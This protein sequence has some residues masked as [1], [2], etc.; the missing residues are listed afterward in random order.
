MAVHDRR[1]TPKPPAR[2]AAARRG[3]QAVA[4]A[5]W[6][7]FGEQSGI[8]EGVFDQAKHPRDGVPPNP[9]W[10][11][12]TG[13]GGGGTGSFLDKVIQRNKAVADLTGGASPGMR[14]SDELAADLQ[15]AGRVAGA[16]AAGLRTGGKSVINGTATA[17]KNVVTLGLDN[18]QLELIGVTKQDRD[19]GYNEAV[20]IATASGEVLIAVGTGGITAALSNGGKIAR[21]V[22]RGLV[23]LDA[24]GN[25]VGV[26]R[27][28]YDAKTNG[29]NLSNGT[30]IAAG[31]LGF[32]YNIGVARGLKTPSLL[33]KGFDPVNGFATFEDF[34]DAFGAAGPG[35]AW[36][37]IVEQTINSGKFAAELLHNPANLLKLPHGKGTIHAKI[38]GYY[39]SRRDFTGGLKV[40]EWLSKKSFKEQF[41]F[42]IQK[43]KE[44]GGTQYLPP[45][46]R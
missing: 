25:I 20:A 44:F 24:A 45:D 12:K 38:S 34:K 36:H 19:G 28:S 35:L 10:W 13:G 32:G 40:R 22:G 8:R 16:A 4:E 14:R 27:G 33:P 11:A 21:V 1:E 2:P 18:H 31:L 46:L 3:N 5:R 42:G 6:V 17:V 7:G 9:G 26:V 15:A 30:Q 41:E 43:I 39:N 37:H 29:L 23:A